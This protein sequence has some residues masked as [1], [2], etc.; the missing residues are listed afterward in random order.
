MKQFLFF[1]AIACVFWGV[2]TQ[3]WGLFSGLFFPLE[4]AVFFGLAVALLVAALMVRA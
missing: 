2:I 3:G 1:G 4:C